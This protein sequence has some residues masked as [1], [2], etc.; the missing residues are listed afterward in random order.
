MAK[1]K[2]NINLPE[3][4]AVMLASLR[5]LCKDWGSLHE[6]SWSWLWENVERMLKQI[7]GKPAVQ[8]K[9]LSALYASLDEASLMIIRKE[10][11][12]KFFALAPAG[13]DYFKQSTTRLYFIADK[14]VAMTLDMY[15]EPKRMV[16]DI[17]AL[18]LPM[19][20]MASPPTCLGPSSRAASRS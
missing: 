2:G 1:Y 17:S 19:S 20:A 4:K 13:Q 14:L 7:M 6:V 12:Q 11:Y 10:V 15:K 18:G 16:E 8:E 3:Y 5:S 9:A